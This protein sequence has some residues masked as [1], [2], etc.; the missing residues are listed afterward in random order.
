VDKFIGDNDLRD[1]P[2]LHADAPVWHDVVQYDGTL[3]APRFLMDTC[4]AL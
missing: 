2:V 4:E 3:T 1:D